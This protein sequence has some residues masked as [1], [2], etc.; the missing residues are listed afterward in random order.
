MPP[1]QNDLDLDTPIW[2]AAAIAIAA[3]IVDA[4]GKPLLDRA[5][6]K[7]ER[8]L[9]PATKCG[10]EWVSSL[11]QIRNLDNYEASPSK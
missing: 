11:R 1:A 3:G 2:D 7:L 10:R 9:L 5:Y 6:Y 8:R 4:K